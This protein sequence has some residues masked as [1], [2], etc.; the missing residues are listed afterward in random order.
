M[1]VREPSSLGSLVSCAQLQRDCV[2]CQGQ[3][4]FFK[5]IFYFCV[6][7]FIWTCVHAHGEQNNASDPL[8]L[9]L[10]QGVGWGRGACPIL[11]SLPIC[12]H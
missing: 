2:C 9:E 12:L 11:S 4:S 3:L 1:G 10:Q 7:A 6:W 5:K 8:E